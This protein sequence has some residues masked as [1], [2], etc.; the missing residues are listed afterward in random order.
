MRNLWKSSSLIGTTAISACLVIL[1]ITF[2]TLGSERSGLEKALP[3]VSQ[4]DAHRARASVVTLMP[5][6]LSGLN[7]LPEWAIPILLHD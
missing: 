5:S 1:L 4:L 6:I 3:A 7:S 2:H